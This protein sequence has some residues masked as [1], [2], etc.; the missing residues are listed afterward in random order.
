MFSAAFKLLEYWS[1]C[2]LEP[3]KGWE[4]TL[5][6]IESR[7]DLLHRFTRVPFSIFLAHLDI[8]LTIILGHVSR[9]CF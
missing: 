2:C 5:A 8:L 4:D 3:S 1:I 9:L 7:Q 6:E